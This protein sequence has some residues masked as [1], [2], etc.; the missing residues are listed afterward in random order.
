M[1]HTLTNDCIGGGCDDCERDIANLAS[2]EAMLAQAIAEVP[3]GYG[4]GEGSVRWASDIAGTPSGS[5]L[6]ALAIRGAT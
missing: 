5:R 4:P 1:T 2:V 3:D 6:L